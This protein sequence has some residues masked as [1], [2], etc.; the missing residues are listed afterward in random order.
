M[1]ETFNRASVALTTTS[2]TD[3]YQAPNIAASDRAIVLSCLVANVDGT[4]AAEITM[5]IADSSNTVLSRI[6]STITVPADSTIELI[7]NKLILKRGEKLR[8]T[9]ST[10]ND[11]DVTVSVLEIA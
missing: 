7:P 9:A 11:L 1:A 10:A 6:A 3:A 8:A 2:I 4:T 5:L